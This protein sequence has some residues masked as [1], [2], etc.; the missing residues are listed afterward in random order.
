MRLLHS[1]KVRSFGIH[2]IEV[3]PELPWVV[4]PNSVQVK[5]NESVVGHML[6]IA[7]RQP[8]AHIDST[9]RHTWSCLLMTISDA[10]CIEVPRLHEAS[11]IQLF[12][13]RVALS[14]LHARHALGCAY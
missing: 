8:E 3:A 4:Q 9:M 11:V 5:I 10:F 14:I 6:S 12:K 1:A 13:W 7:G 2:S